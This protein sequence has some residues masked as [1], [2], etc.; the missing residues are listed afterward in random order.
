M[1]TTTILKI[2]ASLLCLSVVGA[3]FYVFNALHPQ[4]DQLNLPAGLELGV[5]AEK[6]PT[7]EASESPTPAVKV[8][9]YKSNSLPTPTI[10]PW[11]TPMPTATPQPNPTPM[12]TPTPQ[13]TTTPVPSN[14]PVPT[15][16]IFVSG[17]ICTKEGREK[18]C[19]EPCR[20]PDG[21]SG[22][23]ENPD[24]TNCIVN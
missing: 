16:T 1:K 7:T 9:I 10:P 11:P 17:G 20:L 14:T 4:D 6:P 2:V 19:R 24:R 23:W 3:G 15:P 22:Y 18:N 5:Q 13:P 12:P 21:R 8:K